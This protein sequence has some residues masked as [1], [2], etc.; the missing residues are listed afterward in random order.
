MFEGR[1]ISYNSTD[2]SKKQSVH[3]YAN[4]LFKEHTNCCSALQEAVKQDFIICEDEFVTQTLRAAYNDLQKSKDPAVQYY[5]GMLTYL[6][7]GSQ[8]RYP[9]A[10]PA[11]DWF[12]EAQISGMVVTAARTCLGVVEKYA[13]GG[14]GITPSEGGV[15]RVTEVAKALRDAKAY[16]V[17]RLTRMVTATVNGESKQL[18]I[19]GASRF[20]PK[21]ELSLDIGT[22]SDPNF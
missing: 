10:S 17:N 15:V 19:V 5:I 13:D 4:W 16:L 6:P 12:N 3:W 11:I 9:D 18:R 1:H 21:P 14:W 2:M 20:L 22:L 7:K 8:P